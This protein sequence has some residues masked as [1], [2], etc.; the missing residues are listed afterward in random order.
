M[1]EG[2]PSLKI[3]RSLSPLGIKLLNLKSK[4]KPFFIS[5]IT[6]MISEIPCAI[7]V[8]YAAPSAERLNAPIKRKSSPMF[9]MHAIRTNQKGLFESPRARRMLLT[10]L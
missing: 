2:R 5:Q 10:A 7:I 9:A 8:A 1:E 6:E 4:E 3:S